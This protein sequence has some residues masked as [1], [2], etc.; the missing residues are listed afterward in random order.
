M[1]LNQTS[2]RHFIKVIGTGALVTTLSAC[3]GF[4]PPSFGP[5]GGGTDPLSIEVRR[6]LKNHPE[7]TLLDIHITSSSEGT[8]KLS[9][10]VNSDA[11]IYAAERVTYTV[12]GVNFV[13]NT[14]AVID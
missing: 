10:R 13:A 14:L 2:R 8:V 5:R 7:T 12:P 9:G 11:D 1:A 4:N 3:E 6:A